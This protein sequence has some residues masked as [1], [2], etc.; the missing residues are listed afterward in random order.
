M[1]SAGCARPVDHLTSLLTVA[2]TPPADSSPR[3]AALTTAVSD[4]LNYL[5]GIR[6]ANIKLT[7]SEQRKFDVMT[8]I[9]ISLGTASAIFGFTDLADDSKAKVAGIAGALAALTT[10]LLA[11]FRHGEDAEHDRI[12]AKEIE[13]AISDFKYPH[14]FEEF[15]SERKGITDTLN[16][17][18]CLATETR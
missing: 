4:Y 15:R 18:N 16:G 10:S 11:K 1:L 17:L 8:V 12:C 6:I 13:R 3:S 7:L 14:N 9:A 5:N 2:K